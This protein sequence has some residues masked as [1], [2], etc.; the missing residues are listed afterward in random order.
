MRA[1][2]VMQMMTSAMCGSRVTPA[3]LCDDK[4]NAVTVQH[5]A[6]P[7]WLERLLRPV[8]DGPSMLLKCPTCPAAT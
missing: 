2:L 7:L 6:S 3:A 1:I 4:G 5:S 8:C